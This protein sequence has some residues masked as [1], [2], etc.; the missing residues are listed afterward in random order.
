MVILSICERQENDGDVYVTLSYLS[1]IFMFN[2]ELIEICSLKNCL[3]LFLGIIFQEYPCDLFV[4]SL[5]THFNIFSG[6][7]LNDISCSN[8]DG[9]QR[10]N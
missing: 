1:D 9:I 8:T 5:N 6:F 10:T 7:I 4:R 2:F 3:V